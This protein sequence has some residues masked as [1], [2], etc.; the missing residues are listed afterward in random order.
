MGNSR[1]RLSCE[2]MF[3]VS[4]PGQCLNILKTI[5]GLEKKVTTSL[6]TVILLGVTGQVVQ[7]TY[8]VRETSSGRTSSTPNNNL[9]KD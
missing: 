4:V 9:T 8:G 1:H 2:L 5:R 3:C 7:N 6:H